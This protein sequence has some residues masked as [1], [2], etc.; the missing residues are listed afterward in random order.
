MI[1]VIQCENPTGSIALRLSIDALSC[2]IWYASDELRW[3]RHV[4]HS[5]ISRLVVIFFFALFIEKKKK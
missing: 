2:S 4:N 1:S 3:K 5:K